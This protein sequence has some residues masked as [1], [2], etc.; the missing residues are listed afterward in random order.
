LPGEPAVQQKVLL[1][2]GGLFM[3][4]VRHRV[5]IKGS[6]REIFQA[7]IQPSRLVGWWATTAAGDPLPGSEL[8]L[9]F[10][11]LT[12]LV[13]RIAE[14]FED[15]RVKFVNVRG[16]A[17]WVGSI[18]EFDLAEDDHQ[19]RVTLTHAKSEADDESFLYFNTKWPI[20]LVSLKDFIET[21]KGRPFPNDV[22]INHDL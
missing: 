5:G 13:F 1:I 19:V 20:F 21:G 22:R 14:L 2:A 9:G 3:A 17:T 18:L 10:V 6:S 11:G 4:K 8:D 15:R 12:H 16:P 7:L